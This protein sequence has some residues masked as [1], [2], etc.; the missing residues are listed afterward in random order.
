MLNVDESW[1]EFREF[2]EF[3]RKKAIDNRYLQDFSKSCGLQHY[4]FL[5]F[6]KP[7]NVLIIQFII[8][9]ASLLLCSSSPYDDFFSMRSRTASACCS[10]AS[11]LGPRTRLSGRFGKKIGHKGNGGKIWPYLHTLSVKFRMESYKIL[12]ISG[13]LNRLYDF[14]QK[15]FATS[16]WNFMN[17]R[18]LQMSLIK[19][20][21]YTVTNSN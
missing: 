15:H 10:T 3:Q 8:T 5:K 19:Q 17:L 21:L 11:P 9:S 13:N 1:S 16:Q 20:K 14:V 6:P 2:L 18:I 7:D 12:N 4:H